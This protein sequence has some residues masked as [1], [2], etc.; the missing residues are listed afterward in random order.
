MLESQ[1][2]RMS[3]NLF[4]REGAHFIADAHDSADR[5]FFFEYLLHVK[6][7]PPPQLFLMGD[8]F[9]LLVGNVAYGVKKYEHYIAL[10]E[11]IAQVCEVYYF[12]GNHDFCLAQLFLHVKVIPIEEQPLTCKLPSGKTCLL[13]HGDR[14]GDWL[15]RFYTALIRNPFILRF[16]NGCDVLGQGAISK[17]IEQSQAKKNLCKRIPHFATLI[18]RKLSSYPKTEVIAEGHYHQNHAFMVSGVH[19][20]NFPSFACNQSYF[21]VQS[22]SE[23]EFAPMQFRSCPST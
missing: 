3:P 22:S 15:N 16:L 17:A 14:Y 11:E 10:I 1:S 5:S 6:Q 9:D 13:L 21:S 23:T 7:N 4:I 19:Y 2:L 12:E 20:I 18:Q 8:M